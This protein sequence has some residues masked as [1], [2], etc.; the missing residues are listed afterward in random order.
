MCCGYHDLGEWNDEGPKS[1]YRYTARDS[2]VLKP[3]K[4]RMEQP[5]RHRL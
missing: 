3:P 5:V 4:L 1:A 2:L